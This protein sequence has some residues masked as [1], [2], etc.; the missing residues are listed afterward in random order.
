MTYRRRYLA[1]VQAAPVVD[2]VLTDETNPRSVIYQVRALVDHI[3][4]LPLLPGA[5]ARSPQLRLAVAALNELE[6]AEVERLCLP[7]ESGDR[8][9]LEALLR[10]LGTQLPAL[11]DSLSDS[12]LS[13]ATVSRHLLHDEVSLPRR[14]RDP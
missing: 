13:H 1:T 14:I 5:G 3:R 6:L 7:S 8:P 12:Y 11:S 10:K 9:L 2:L 4:P